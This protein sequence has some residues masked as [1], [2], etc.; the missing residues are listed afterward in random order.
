[1]LSRWW[2]SRLSLCYSSQAND[3]R[4]Q[5]ILNI[6]ELSGSAR[7]RMAKLADQLFD[8]KNAEW[9]CAVF[10]SSA[11]E[12]EKHGENKLHFLALFVCS[13]GCYTLSCK[14]NSTKKK[15]TEYFLCKLPPLIKHARDKVGAECFFC[16]TKKSSLVSNRVLIIFKRLQANAKININR[17][18]EKFNIETLSGFAAAFDWV[19]NRREFDFLS[20]HI[21]LHT[22]ARHSHTPCNQ[23]FFSSLFTPNFYADCVSLISS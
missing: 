15:I 11:K 20:L 9:I 19:R 10:A 23:L 17:D 6:L 12:E 5:P 13:T 21:P 18:N 7:A 1:M 8:D 22:L 3:C 16:C 4:W 14:T 2:R